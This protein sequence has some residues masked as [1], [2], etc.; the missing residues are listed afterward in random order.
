MTVKI[1]DNTVI[2]VSINELHSINLIQLCSTRYDITTTHHVFTEAKKGFS[3]AVIKEMSNY[4]SVSNSQNQR[5]DE[6]LSWLELRFPYLHKGELSTFLMAVLDY[7][8]TNKKYYYVT[9]DGRMRKTIPKILQN[10]AFIN[11]CG[12]NK[13]T[14]NCTGTIGLIKRLY[15]KGSLT[16]NQIEEIITDLRNSTFY[17][18]PSLLNSLRRTPQ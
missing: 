18:T 9:D 14:F 17:I 5:F 13:G 1:F 7:S 15:E 8:Q 10:Q 11:M 3:K 4:I 2:S 16:D 12:K 6:V